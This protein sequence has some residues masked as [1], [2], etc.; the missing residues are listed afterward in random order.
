MT[1]RQ[2]TGSNP[3]KLLFLCSGEGGNLKFFHELERRGYIPH[4]SMHVI[5]NKDCGAFRYAKANGITASLVEQNEHFDECLRAEIDQLAC[6]LV[7]STWTKIID[8]ETVAKNHGKLINL[9]YSLLPAFGGLVGVEPLELAYARGC[10][11]V[12]PTVHFVERAVDS[13]P[14]ICQGVFNTDRPIRSS[15][16][17]MYRSGCIAL[18][19]AVNGILGITHLPV[20]D[21]VDAEFSPKPSTTSEFHITEMF[22]EDVSQL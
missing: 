9:H 14:I 15:C 4:Y 17:Q 19:I 5:T 20:F 3:S 12:G 16:Q 1:G 18:L 11:F 10:K 21:G 6:D 22:W 13:G 8:A 2:K 7:I